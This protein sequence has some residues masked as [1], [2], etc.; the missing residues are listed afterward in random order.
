MRP[1]HALPPLS[2]PGPN[3]RNKLASPVANTPPTIFNTPSKLDRF[4]QSVEKN[5]VPGVV[6]F[7]PMLSEKGY[8][9]D[10]MHLIN[11]SDLVDIGMPPGD[12]IR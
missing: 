11:I 7:H 1:D 8:G 6:S 9:P 12:A 4:L 2:T 5:G 10:I 3:P